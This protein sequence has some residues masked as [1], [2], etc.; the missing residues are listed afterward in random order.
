[1]KTFKVSGK[2]ARHANVRS[3]ERGLQLLEL[4]NEEGG[5]R[6]SEA[7]RLLNLPRPTAH[8]L[9]ETLEELGYVRR[10]PSDNRFVVT[11]KSR[12]LSGG[13]DA[14]VQMSEAVGPI[15][16]QLLQEVVWPVNLS[17]HRGG[18]MVVR[19]TTHERSPLSVDKAMVGREVPMLRTATGRAYLSFCSEKER[20]EILEYLHTRSD[21]EDEACLYPKALDTM[22]ATCRRNGYGTRL[23]E[24]FV[25]KTSSISL[26]ILVDDRARACIT[27][28]WLTQAMSA[29][30]AIK[31]FFPPLK[32][33]AGVI[34]K[35]VAKHQ[36]SLPEAPTAR[37]STGLS[38]AAD[39]T[40]TGCNGQALPV[41]GNS[42][43]A[44]RGSLGSVR[45]HSGAR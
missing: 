28:V 26:P 25:P 18:M 44:A 34:A 16:S 11:I 35:E 31:E 24:A 41:L 43:S 23:G 20:A 19:E 5:I 29:S 12:R 21:P 10:T 9:L 15:L 36:W 6:P 33:A 13:Y 3:L 39:S 37:R 8:R 38:V 45:F 7:G 42:H 30:R 1:M 14:D 40:P 32:E 2:V 22:I 27:V 17:T 4:V